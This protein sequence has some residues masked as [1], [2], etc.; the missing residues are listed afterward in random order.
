MN[1]CPPLLHIPQNS[2]PKAT[3][4]WLSEVL[5]PHSLCGLPLPSDGPPC[6]ASEAQAK[7]TKGEALPEVSAPCTGTQQEP[8]ETAMLVKPPLCKNHSP[9]RSSLLCLLKPEQFS[10]AGESA[11]S[12]CSRV[13]VTLVPLCA[14]PIQKNHFSFGFWSL[15]QCCPNLR[16]VPGALKASMPSLKPFLPHQAGSSKGM[17]PPPCS[18]CKAHAASTSCLTARL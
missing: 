8:L 18:L 14:P 12:C 1:L 10:G 11:S 4:T 6:P 5:V 13:P 16:Q 3:P 2:N 15:P 17:A 9:R 7:S